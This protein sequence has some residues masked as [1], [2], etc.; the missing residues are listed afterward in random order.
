MPRRALYAAAIVFAVGMFLRLDAVI[1]S[2]WLD[3]RGTVP[4]SRPS[5]I[6]HRQELPLHDPLVVEWVQSRWPARYRMRPK[7]YGGVEL[8]EFHKR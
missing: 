1:D 6:E 5:Q 2:V 8:L 7:D 4:I 3:E